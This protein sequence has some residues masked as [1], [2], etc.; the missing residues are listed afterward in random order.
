MIIRL[1]R[2]NELRILK[3]LLAG[4][5]TTGLVT[6]CGSDS[7]DNSLSV[8]D[9]SLDS[10]EG[11]EV[12]SDSLVGTWVATYKLSK[13]VQYDGRT[14][15][16]YEA[17]KVYFILRESAGEVVGLEASVCSGTFTDVTVNGQEIDLTFL[18][19][20][21]TG[22]ISENTFI[23]ASS[24]ITDHYFF[25]DE[26]LLESIDANVTYELV[27][28]SDSVQSFGSYSLELTDQQ[29]ESNNRQI[30]K[31]AYCFTQSR[32]VG[33]IVGVVAGAGE[34]Y[35]IGSNGDVESLDFS[36]SVANGERSERSWFTTGDVSLPTLMFYSSEG[37]AISYSVNEETEFTNQITYTISDSDN[38]YSID[39]SLEIQ[40][41]MN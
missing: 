29:V 10:Y 11:R 5:L 18:R 40:L 33:E 12:S 28:I 22:T 39:G 3:Y 38:V 23:E 34:E 41:P 14:S 24:D 25:D 4:I 2:I 1:L 6:G 37:D 31:D 32:D 7:D 17:G 36:H 16:S 15:R 27:K 30:E 26:S 20:G 13:E 35:K 21:M 8:E 19:G 9:Y